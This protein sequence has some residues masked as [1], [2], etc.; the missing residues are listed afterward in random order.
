MGPRGSA[1]AA[2]AL[3]G[4]RRNVDFRS[5]AGGWIPPSFCT[6]DPPFPGVVG[7][8]GARTD[9][10]LGLPFGFSG[11]RGPD[12]AMVAAG[13]IRTQPGSQGVSA[14]HPGR[15]AVYPHDCYGLRRFHPARRSFA[16]GAGSDVS[17][18]AQGSRRPAPGSVDRY[19]SQPF[20][21][22]THSGPSRRH[23]QRDARASGAGNRRSDQHRTRSTG[24]MF[25][26][27]I[28]PAGRRRRLR[29]PGQS[30]NLLR[31]PRI[32]SNSRALAWAIGTCG[33]APSL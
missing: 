5:G 25:A 31:M 19:P 9:L 33:N 2:S 6:R 23:G 10:R 29:L 18:P 22:R 20:S 28:A 3:G 15:A 7:R 21:E 14:H 16:A 32:M 17:R 4:H 1:F 30:R 24:H 27:A 8:L 26:A 12:L 11:C 13:A